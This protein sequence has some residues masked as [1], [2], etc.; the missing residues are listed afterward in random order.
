M[1][2]IPIIV[3]GF[4][5]SGTTLLRRLIDAHPSISCPG[6]TFLLSAAARF[7]RGETIA[8]GLDYGVIGGLSSLGVSQEELYGK[9]RDLV[10]YFMRRH[11][12]AE[13]KKR[14]AIKTAVDAFYI[15]EIE[16]LY[17]REAQFICMVRHGLDVVASC[18]DL[19]VGNEMFIRELYGYVQKTPY[20]HN[21]YMAAWIEV[22]RRLI[23]FVTAHPENSCL[24][25][26]ED[27]LD[28][29]EEV[30]QALLD[31]LGEPF[32]PALIES[33][34]RHVGHI[35]LG[36]WKTYEKDS[37]D[38][39]S[40]GRWKNLSPEIL[41]RI[42]PMANP[43]L[44]EL[45]YDAITVGDSPRSHEDALKRYEVLMKMKASRVVD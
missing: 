8:G 36:D 15:D 29:P 39:S 27:L 45:G 44:T 1:T 22:T 31:F 19:T 5:R 34:P 32:D 20:P 11:A 38:R 28:Q 2:H 35:G 40:V 7:L 42:A 13:K 6:E 37:L 12:D 25:R 24:I 21:A 10:D 33:A 30:M 14:W 4:P 43:V 26:Y 3:L 16:A 9:L 23:E 18:D 41:Q 17:G